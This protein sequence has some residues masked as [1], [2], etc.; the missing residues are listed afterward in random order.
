MVW[1]AHG[2]IQAPQFT[3]VQE[4]CMSCPRGAYTTAAVTH[5][6]SVV[7]WDIHVERLIKSIAAIH[8]ALGACYAAHYETVEA[9]VG[10]NVGLS[11]SSKSR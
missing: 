4:F 2:E 10:R 7:D 5:D 11:G 3:S 8:A 6:Y 1:V 9:Q